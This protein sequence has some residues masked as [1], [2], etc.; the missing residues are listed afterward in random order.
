MKKSQLEGVGLEQII[1]AIKSKTDAEKIALLRKY[2]DKANAAPEE[3]ATEIKKN[4]CMFLLT[5]FAL[6]AKKS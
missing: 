4:L 3:K 2:Y 5:R 1:I 6:I